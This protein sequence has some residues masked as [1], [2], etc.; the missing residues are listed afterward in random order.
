MSEEFKG[1]IVLITG[2]GSGIGRAAA[3]LYAA[4]GAR[5]FGADVNEGGL[6]ETRALIDPLVVSSTFRASM[7]Q[8]RLRSRASSLTSRIQPVG[9]ISPSTMRALPGART[10]SRIIRRRISIG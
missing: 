7:L 9:L 10:L 4:R 1:K 5:V 8:T 3:R 2:A 6:A